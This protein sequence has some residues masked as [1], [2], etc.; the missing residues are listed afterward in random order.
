MRCEK[1][2]YRYKEYALDAMRRLAAKSVR[3]TVP[4]RVYYCEQCM[5]WHMTS[6]EH[7]VH[8]KPQYTEDYGRIDT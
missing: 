8:A 1:S 4:C 5:G 6:Q 3:D 2:R 7:I